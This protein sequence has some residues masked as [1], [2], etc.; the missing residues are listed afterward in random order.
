MDPA[1]GISL[2]QREIGH[3]VGWIELDRA[4]EM[5]ACLFEQILAERGETLAAL[6]I[7]LISFNSQSLRRCNA[8]GTARFSFQLQRIHECADDTVL[9]IENVIPG[10]VNLNGGRNFSA[11]RLKQPRSD[12]DAVTRTLIAP[13]YQPTRVRLDA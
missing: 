4:L 7:L 10:A 9:K 2:T 12:A 1:H 8:L 11:G 3:S 6:R 13:V 5:P